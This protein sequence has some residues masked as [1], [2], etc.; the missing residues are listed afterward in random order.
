MNTKRIPQY[1]A[2]SSLLLRTRALL[3]ERNDFL[4]VYKHTGISPS[5]LWR[6]ATGRIRNPSVNRVQNLYEYLTA[7]KLDV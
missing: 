7:T 1:D 5:W 2:P 6:L 3:T 4:D